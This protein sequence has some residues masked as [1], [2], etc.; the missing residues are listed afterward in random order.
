MVEFNWRETVNVLSEERSE[1][2]WKQTT[3]V[4]LLTLNNVILSNDFYTALI[5][6]I[7]HS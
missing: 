4:Y 7:K 3:Y 5:M 1:W 6:S 2:R